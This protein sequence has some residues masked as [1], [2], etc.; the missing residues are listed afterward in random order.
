MYAEQARERQRELGKTHGD[1]LKAN[2]P[3][4]VKGEARDKA[5]AVGVSGRIVQPGSGS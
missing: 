2:L 4:G 3:E 1:T 5:A